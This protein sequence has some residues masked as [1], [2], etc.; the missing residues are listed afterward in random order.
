MFRSKSASAEGNRSNNRGPKENRLNA[1]RAKP[2]TLAQTRSKMA[3]HS[4]QPTAN[5]SQA[6]RAT[7]TA[8]EQRWDTNSSSRAWRA[9]HCPTSHRPRS[10]RSC[11]RSHGLHLLGLLVT[12]SPVEH[13][14]MHLVD[15]VPCMC[16]PVLIAGGA[17]EVER[18][19]SPGEPQARSRS[20]RRSKDRTGDGEGKGTKG[21]ATVREKRRNKGVSTRNA[22]NLR[23]VVP[24]TGFLNA[25][26]GGEGAQLRRITEL[27]N[28]SNA[29]LFLFH[30][31]D[32]NR[33]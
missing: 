4:H 19:A 8:P 28:P 27:P 3:R 7:R 15:T 31:T 25:R 23:E 24:R 33:D 12:D 11:L 29:E 18:S 2:T 16:L 21:S 10:L 20:T 5:K 1:S 32:S 30:F 14:G 26:L 13:V 22:S 6:L 17:E 9:P